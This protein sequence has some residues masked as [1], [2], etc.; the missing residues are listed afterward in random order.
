L[1]RQSFK[2]LGQTDSEVGFCFLMS[3][4]KKHKIRPMVQ[5]RYIGFTD[6]DIHS[7]YRILLEIN[8]QGAGPLNVIFTDGVHLFC[9]R[10]ISGQRPLY[11]LKRQYPFSQTVLRDCDIQIDL[12]LQKGMTESGVVVA[13][14]PLSSE[15]WRSFEHGQLIAFRDG[16]K[17]AD[18][19]G[20]APF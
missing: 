6:K 10:D 1:L 18:I 12:N 20:N 9:Y 19:G 8:I 16:K 15:N 17:V 11:Y 13:S 2:A 5:G 4:L 14:V 3:Q 7:I